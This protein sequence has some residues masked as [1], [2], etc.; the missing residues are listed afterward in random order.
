MR[1]KKLL[2]FIVITVGSAW[3]LQSVLRGQGPAI[4]QAET[5]NSKFTI[6]VERRSDLS[7]M[8]H[9]WYVFKSK[10]KGDLRWHEI[11]KQLHGEPVEL[12]I[13]QIRFISP[14]VGYL[15]FQLKYAVSIDGGETWSLFDF[16][17]HPSYKPEQ[18]DYSRIADV[19]IQADG[20]GHVMMFRYDMTQ[21]QAMKFLT[22]DFGQHWELKP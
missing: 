17:S 12:P 21:G 14:D 5:S 6:R 9:Y 2:A 16:G 1:K 8:M 22:K 20:S 15:F 3:I 18:L 4:E 19:K 10:K 13:K 7:S 11:T